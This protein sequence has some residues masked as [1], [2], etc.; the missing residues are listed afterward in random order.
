[1]SL[2]RL[3]SVLAVLAVLAV[4]GTTVTTVAAYKHRD[5]R[6]VLHRSGFGRGQVVV[7]RAGDAAF[8]VPP[9][10]EG[11]TRKGRD[12]RVYY[13]D[14]DGDPTVGVRGPAVFREGYCAAEPARSNRGF[15]G[16]THPVAGVGVR[17]ANAALGR[18]WLRA[19]AL[20]ADLRTVAPHTR[21]RTAG[22]TLAD[23][24]AAVRST[25]RITVTDR[26]PCTAPA[27]ELTLVS[28]DAGGRV[29]TLVM[30]RDAG[31]R[32]TVTDG[33]A[34]LVLGTL[35]RVGR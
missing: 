6:G 30:V 24:S 31:V 4:L 26:G 23:G 8:E 15:V 9:R 11:W 32:G 28:L 16:F 27:V 10:T 18:E 22:F 29:A 17:A 21:L 13:V 5:D 7:D 12:L 35:H 3:A 1:M 19:V 25:A 33:L 34:D 2:S 20:N 14:R